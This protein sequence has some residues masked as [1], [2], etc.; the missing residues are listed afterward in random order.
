MSFVAQ[1]AVHIFAN[2][3]AILAASRLID[4]FIWS[5][6]SLELVI[7]GAV[8]GIMNSLIRPALKLLSLPIIILTLG[9][10]SLAI[11]IFLLILASNI[12]PSLEIR[13]FW[14]AFWGVIV[15]SIT[16]NIIFSI[17]KSKRFD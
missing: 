15:I 11:N 8:L 6:S 1:I 3:L 17:F 13:G 2:S 5:G 7:A 4:G 10:F 9:L 12:L 14:T 16:N